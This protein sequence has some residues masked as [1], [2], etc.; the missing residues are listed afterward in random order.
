MVQSGSKSQADSIAG[1]RDMDGIDDSSWDVAEGFVST[2][3]PLLL[4]GKLCGP[5][6][7][8]KAPSE[9]NAGQRDFLFRNIVFIN[10]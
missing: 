8:S 1:N 7:Y 2:I 9:E 4:L 5:F 10:I 6:K 3:R